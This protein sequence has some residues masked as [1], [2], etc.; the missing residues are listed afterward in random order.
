M[1]DDCFPPPQLESVDATSR[2]AAV[3][4][5]HTGSLLPLPTCALQPLGTQRCVPLP[6]LRL[7]FLEL[8][9]GLQTKLI[10][11]LRLLRKGP[12]CLSRSCPSCPDTRGRVATSSQATG[13][14]HHTVCARPLLP[15][16]RGDTFRLPHPSVRRFQETPQPLTLWCLLAAW[17][18][19]CPGGTGHLKSKMVPP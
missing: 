4:G 10:L 13:R 2:R 17:M 3:V 1:G 19:P 9:R 16:G 6:Q 8:L 5:P 11:T 15:A 12:C 14:P 18:K 7:H